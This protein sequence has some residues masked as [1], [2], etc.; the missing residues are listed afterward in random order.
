MMVHPITT[1]IPGTNT[2][3]RPRVT[4]IPYSTL[5]N[6]IITGL[7]RSR[8]LISPSLNLGHKLQI[9][10]PYQSLIKLPLLPQSIRIIL[11][12]LLM[13]LK[14][15]NLYLHQLLQARYFYRKVCQTSIMRGKVLR[16]LKSLTTGFRLQKLALRLSRTRKRP[17]RC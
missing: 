17:R 9:C 14:Y 15:R 12:L 1:T 2:N 7:P 8:V 6:L 5:N 11:L 16:G 4:I 10:Q 13:Q 3:I